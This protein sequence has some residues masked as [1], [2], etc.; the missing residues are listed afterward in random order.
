MI[1]LLTS[2]SIAY[3]DKAVNKLPTENQ[4]S[5]FFSITQTQFIEGNLPNEDTIID[6]FS[7]CSAPYPIQGGGAITQLKDMNTKILK[8]GR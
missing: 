8:I 2:F 5:S 4:I 7:L 1:E 3:N 6:C